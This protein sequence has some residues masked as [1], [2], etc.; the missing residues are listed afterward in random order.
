[1]VSRIRDLE[2]ALGTARPRGVSTGE[3]MNRV[4]LAKSL[5][6]A[7]DID[8]GEVIDRGAVDMKS[9]GRGLQPNDLDRLVG[10]TANRGLSAGDFFFTT[11]LTDAV[12]K[13]RDV[14]LPPSVGR[15]GALPRLGT[16]STADSR[17]DFLEFH[18]SYKDLEIDPAPP[19]CPT[20]PPRDGLT[21]HLPDL[22][23]GDFI[24]N[25]ALD[26]DVWE[27]SVPE[28][29]RVIDAPARCGRWFTVDDDPVVVATMGGFTSDR[30]LDPSQRPTRYER[31]AAGLERVDKGGVRLT[32]QTL[33]PYP[34][35]HG[36]PELPQP[37]P[38]PRRHRRVVAC[39]RSSR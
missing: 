27:R 39:Y 12:A 29:Q 23:S 20:A 2:E 17:P 22:F 16:G 35:L 21:T 11:D 5:V 3:M 9:P 6:A 30:H 34:W 33:P 1:M 10:R 36:W 13:A 4:N 38:R 26:D 31:V 7:R 28:L 37:L 24:V 32:A 19:A 25:L 15:A 14:R 8:P 18:F